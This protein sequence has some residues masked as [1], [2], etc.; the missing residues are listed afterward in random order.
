MKIRALQFSPQLGNIDKNLGFHVKKIKKAINDKINLIIFPELSICG[1]HLKDIV[2]DIA[3][4]NN[5]PTIRMLKE[6]SKKIASESRVSLIYHALDI[7]AELQKA[8]I[9]LNQGKKYVQDKT[10]R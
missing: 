3:M 6:L 9:C 1:Y 8:E 4:K 10:F 5:D 7:G 2:Y